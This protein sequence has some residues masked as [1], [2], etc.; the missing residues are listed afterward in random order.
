MILRSGIDLIEPVR[1]ENMKPEIRER[2]LNRVFTPAEQE[3]CGD[4]AQRLAGRFAC[5]EAVSKALG[6]G[7]GKVHW[8]DVEILS[9][10][11]GE[12]VLILHGEAKRIADETG[13]TLWSVSIT[14]IKEAAAAIATA[15]SVP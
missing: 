14:H 7:F 3:L 13:L 1:F 2:F 15:M 8:T 10:S 9:G 6:T 4:N 5:K 12:P 11:E